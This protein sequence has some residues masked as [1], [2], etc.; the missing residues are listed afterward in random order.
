MVAGLPGSGKSY[1]AKAQVSETTYLVDDPKSQDEIPTI[2]FLKENGYSTLIVVDPWF[3][4]SSIR[5]NA[6]KSILERYNISP[7]WIF[8]EN[9][10]E[11]CVRNVIIRNDGRKVTDFIK[12]VS[13]KYEIPDNLNAIPVWRG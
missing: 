10:V 7:E 8:F 6:E 3:C 11:A 12:N 1:W 5:M 9:D 13:Q 4:V 2:N